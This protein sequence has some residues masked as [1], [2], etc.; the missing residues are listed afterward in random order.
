M[1]TCGRFPMPYSARVNDHAADAAPGISAPPRP[2]GERLGLVTGIAAYGIWGFFPLLFPLLLPAGPLEILA[3]RVLWSMLA[4]GLV[5][6]ALR[7]PWGWL[8]D[9]L[10][11]RQLPWMLLGSLLIGANWLTFIWAI[12]NNHVV[13]SSLGYF[14]NPLVNI[15]LGVLVFG[16]KMSRGGLIGTLL[17]AAGVTVIA[18]QNWA[19]LWVSLTLAA[20]FGL[21]GLVKKRATL[22]ALEGLFLESGLLTPLAVAYWVY[23]AATGASTFGAGLGHSALLI[24]AGILTALPLWLFAIAAPRLPLGV[25]GVLQYVAPTIQ[26]LLGLTVFKQVVTPSY[27]AGLILVWCGSVVYL[28]TV[29]SRTRRAR[30]ARPSDATAPH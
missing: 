30:A 11:P 10:A 13:E 29:F 17:A 24:L 3:H 2:A 16:E 15:L 8:R 18:W 21:Y 26:F 20:S 12:N 6:V 27:W 5:L 25:V 28:A 14:I 9:A 7:H 19:G 22:P 1:P 4:V 23:L